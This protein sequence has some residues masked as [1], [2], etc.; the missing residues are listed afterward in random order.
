MDFSEKY[1]EDD[2]PQQ[3]AA[4]HEESFS[5]RLNDAREKSLLARSLGLAGNPDKVMD[6]GC[7]PGRFWPTIA[8]TGVKTFT[9]LDVSVPMVRFAL[10]HNQALSCSPFGMVGSVLALPLGDDSADCVIAMRLLH[11]FGTARERLQALRELSRVAW[12]HVII[13]VWV[14]GNYKSWR[15]NRLEVS[16]STRKY[17]NRHVVNREEFERHFKALNLKVIGCFDLVPFYSQWRYYVLEK[18][19]AKLNP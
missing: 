15:R 14:D 9:A 19:S 2:F 1:H 3:Y 17:Q 6:V 7:G 11:H 18:P 8:G 13:S 16:R 12:R 5:R 10:A 4:K